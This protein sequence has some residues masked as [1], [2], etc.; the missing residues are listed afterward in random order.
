M[1]GFSN[2]ADFTGV[3]FVAGSIRGERSFGLD[4]MGRLHSPMKPLIWKADGNESRC[5]KAD[6]SIATRLKKGKWPGALTTAQRF[7]PEGARVFSLYPEWRTNVSTDRGVGG[8]L[9]A[10]HWWSP[11]D[12]EHGIELVPR[13]VFESALR[14][15]HGHNFATCSCGFYAYLNG[16][17]EYAD[18]P[19]SITGII[20]G[21]GETLI[22]TRGFRASKARI[23][24]LA[25]PVTE[26][27]TADY[28]ENLRRQFPTVPIFD[29][30]DVLRMEFP[31]TD[32][33]E[34]MWPEDKEEIDD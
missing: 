19:W 27:I 6:I 25:A 13:L 24:A 32:V 14:E 3:P 34:F 21:S 8:L 28:V 10:V 9:V 7:I 4:F 17:N 33:T 20:E 18:F 30:P 12:G 29:N 22:G 2:H 26:W 16:C 31:T 11:T 15:D 23:L 5:L 1:S